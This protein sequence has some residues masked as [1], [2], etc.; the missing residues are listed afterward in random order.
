MSARS[1]RVWVLAAA[2][3]M[4]C[5]SFA[6]YG[7]N[8]TTGF[9]CVGIM[10]QL[11]GT[12]FSQFGSGVA[13]APNW[14]LT[15]WHVSGNRFK[16]NGVDYTVVGSQTEP[17][18][19][20][21]KLVQVTPAIPA[22]QQAS[23]GWADWTGANGISGRQV[24]IVGCGRSATQIATGWSP[25]T[26]TEGTKRV[27]LNTLDWASTQTLTISGTPKTS[28][29]LFYDIDQPN[30]SSNPWSL[31]GPAVRYEGGLGY[32]DSGGGM[33]IRHGGWALVAINNA[34]WGVGGTATTGTYDF[35]D[36]GSGVAIYPYKS[37][38]QSVIGN[39]GM[40]IRSWP[41]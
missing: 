9:E 33:F 35:G 28:L 38:I 41:N 3:A 39:L 18:G 24:A 36:A 2:L 12:S 29:H 17:T 21:L 26:G 23:I 25:T 22:N 30:N 15:A 19:A 10:G 7:S 31:G 11:S 37:W 13:V 6:V 5:S 32:L 14:V 4:S 20:D 27:A 40:T 16:L 8:Q 34:V 1:L